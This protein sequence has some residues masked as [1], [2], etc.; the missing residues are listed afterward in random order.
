MSGRKSKRKG[1]GAR[2][3]FALIQPKASAPKLHH[4]DV[5]KSKSKTP[6]RSRS[7]VLA[8]PIRNGAS[9]VAS[10]LGIRSGATPCG[11][12]HPNIPFSAGRSK[13]D[14]SIWQRLGHFYLALTALE[15]P[16]N[17]A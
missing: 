14:I 16:W 10:A 8:V 15:Q 3:A 13:P 7:R 11:L 17:M 5:V 1:R 9:P 12:T 4:P 2:P 6:E